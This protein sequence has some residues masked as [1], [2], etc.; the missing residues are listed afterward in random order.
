[1][2]L[3]PGGE[4]D[5]TITVGL[6]GPRQD[7]GACELDRAVEGLGRWAR[8]EIGDGRRKDLS[9]VRGPASSNAT[10]HLDLR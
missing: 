6:L 8:G 2:A 9:I 4:V 10:S 7:R 3:A 1:M 5:P